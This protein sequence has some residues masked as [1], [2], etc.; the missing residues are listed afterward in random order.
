MP[1]TQSRQEALE[2]IDRS[3]TFSWKERTLTSLMFEEARSAPRAVAKLL[4]ANAEEYLALGA[5]LRSAPPSGIATIARGSSD[6]AAA[7]C[8]YLM[9]TRLGRLVTSLPM[10]L[11]TLYHAPLIAERLISTSVRPPRPGPGRPRRPPSRRT[12]ATSTCRW[13]WRARTWWAGPP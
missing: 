4:D 7:Y 12:A 1:L 5:A 3:W 8:A 13:S 9:T 11:V 10:S 2:Q 6:H